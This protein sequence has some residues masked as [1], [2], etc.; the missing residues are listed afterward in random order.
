MFLHKPF[1][2]NLNLFI[3]IEEK[4]NTPLET[5]FIFEEVEF[6]MYLTVYST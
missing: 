6:N 2:R 1:D 4:D 3:K 5:P